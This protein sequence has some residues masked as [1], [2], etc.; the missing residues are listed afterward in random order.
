M[1]A[2]KNMYLVKGGGYMANVCNRPSS[3]G[4]ERG[5]SQVYKHY[6]Q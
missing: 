4:E 2:W 6:Q 3:V 1:V 5:I